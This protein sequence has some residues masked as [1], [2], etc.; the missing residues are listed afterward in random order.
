MIG[1][2]FSGYSSSVMQG[3]DQIHLAKF[4]TMLFFIFRKTL[5]FIHTKLEINHTWR[6]I[7]YNNFRYSLQF[8]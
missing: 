8:D 5:E 6:L 4:N 7:F 1:K 2:W 3:A